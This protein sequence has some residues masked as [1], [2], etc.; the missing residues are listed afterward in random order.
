MSL[1]IRH[2]GATRLPKQDPGMLRISA[3]LK[4]ILGITLIVVTTSTASQAES[5]PN[6]ILLMGDDHGWEETGY[7]GHPYL[8]TP[9]LDEMAAT[10]LRLDHFYAA[11]PSCS[12][13]RGSVLTGRHPN[14]YGTFT[15]NWSMRPEEIT[16]G[17]IAK[18][19][20]YRT[21]HLG[22]WHVGPVKTDSPTNPGAMGF[23]QWLSH[24]NF[25]ELNPHFSHNGAPPT[26]FAGE[27][28]EIVI[29]KTIEFIEQSQQKTKPFLAV[30]W[31]GSPHEP[32]SGLEHDLALYDNLPKAYQV[33][34][35]SLTSNETGQ[36]VRRPLGEVLRER[37]AE[38][39]AM[40]RAIG[41]LRDHLQR[42]GLRQNTLLWYCGDNGTPSSGL[43]A[44]PFRGQK[45]Q[46][47]EGG[48]RVP[49]VIEWPAKIEQPRVSK[50][51][52][53]T[54]DMLPTLCDLTQQSLPQRP[55]DGLS[56]LPLLNGNMNTR[57]EPIC[58]WS[59]NANR[60]AKNG[61]KPY[62]E[63]VQQ[64]GTTPLVKL[65]NGKATRTFRN[66]HHPTISEED[67]V[68]SRAIIDQQYKL[69]VS[70]TNKDEKELFNLRVDPAEK[71]NLAN[72]HTEKA[73]ELTQKL[74]IWQ[75]SVLKSLTEADYD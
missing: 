14:R 52:T 55:L 38:I 41:K 23:D 1:A 21:A 48:I 25:F 29:Q 69:V 64:E 19:A 75:A 28:S 49:G 60:E 63:P 20:G 66:F 54:S 7:N 5:A 35:V 10:G 16:I 18:K 65:M 17:H 9:V 15:P 56:L 33:R 37:Y 51:N 24:D 39:T 59:Y 36:R 53:V 42:A 8:K 31:F 46:M 34:S 43:L 58:F 27:S 13:T 11:H 47:Y 68:G 4:R 45:G 2:S 40:D 57:S 61:L 71:N 26:Q 62:F 70:G 6:I 30:V 73:Q 67:F 12:P 3:L 44:S 22:K 32:Y 74:R 50:V 72:S